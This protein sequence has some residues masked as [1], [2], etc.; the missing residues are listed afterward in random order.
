MLQGIL[1]SEN[2]KDDRIQG[3][4][5]VMRAEAGLGSKELV[6]EDLVCWPAALDYALQAMSRLCMD[7]VLT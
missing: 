4:G 6:T 5:Q 3:W 2:G 7:L 1:G